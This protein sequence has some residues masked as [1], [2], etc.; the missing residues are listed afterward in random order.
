M[1]NQ[2]GYIRQP[3]QLNVTLNEATVWDD[4][5][6]QT[7]AINLT[8]SSFDQSA[9]GWVFMDA[10]YVELRFE[11]LCSGAP[12]AFLTGVVPHIAPDN[13]R[14]YELASFCPAALC[15]LET[16]LRKFLSA[17]LFSIVAL[18]DAATGVW[19]KKA[20]RFNY[21]GQTYT[22]SK[23]ESRRERITL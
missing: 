5:A 18:Q 6:Q 12:P 10:R 15:D 23:C 14:L 3:G 7:W 21:R 2:L 16:R 8:V 1:I 20:T 19:S 17:C 22:L 9:S 4:H 13:N 11:S